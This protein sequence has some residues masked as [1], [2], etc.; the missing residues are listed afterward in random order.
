MYSTAVPTR[1]AAQRDHLPPRVGKPPVNAKPASPAVY[2]RRRATALAVLIA[3]V[4]VGA[5]ALGHGSSAP[6]PIA[7]DRAVA[8]PT[9]KPPELPRG[10]RTILLDFRV[11]SYD[12]AAQGLELD[13]LG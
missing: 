5:L 13:V 3:L 1:Q 10:G 12:G 8:A 6:K 11:F 2:R 9:P 7:K 4:A